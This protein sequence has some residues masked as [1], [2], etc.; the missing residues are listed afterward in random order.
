MATSA[1]NFVT[2]RLRQSAT[3]D[4]KFF[5]K[6]LMFFELKV[7]ASVGGFAGTSFLFPLIVP[8]Q[9]S[10][11]DEPFTVEVTPTQG[12]GLYV[13]ENGIVQRMIKISG[14]TGFKP[15]KLNANGTRALGIKAPEKR[16]FGRRLDPWVLE[17]LSGQRHIQYLQDAVFRTYGDLKRD[18]N[19]SE[20]VKLIFHI[21]KDEESWLVI[22]QKFSIE[23][24]SSRATLYNYSID[25]LVVDA[26]VAVDEDFTEDTW[27]DKVKDAVQDIKTAIDLAQGAINDLTAVVGQI[28]GYVKNIAVIIDGVSGVINAASNFVQG[29]TDLVLS[30]LAIVESMAEVTD[31]ALTAYDTLE[32]S[33]ELLQNPPIPPSI[34]VKLMQL[35][36][37]M[38]RIASHPEVT[39]PD[40]GNAIILNNL[41][42]DARSRITA[43]DRSS[44]RTITSLADA[45]TMGTAVTAGDI[46]IADGQNNVPKRVS[47]N[48]RSGKR[49]T[50]TE[51]DTLASLAASHLGDARRWQDLAV[52]NG[53]KPPF[54]NKQAS[55]DLTKADE[56]VLPG[57]LGIGDKIVIPS[58]SKGT[59][60]L[61]IL[62]VLG[63]KP[64]EPLEVQLLGRDIALELVADES[65]PGNP[66][67]DIPIDV[68]G[69]SVDV[70]TVAGLANLSQGLTLRLNTEKGTDTLYK[71]LGLERVVGL[72]IAPLDLETMRFRLSQA[73]QQDPRIASVRQVVFQGL[74]NGAELDPSIPLDA[75]V[76]DI[77]AEVRG[78]TEGV[79]VRLVL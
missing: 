44:P 55:L 32:Q 47:P 57:S 54:I 7:P 62:P 6:M 37:A 70:K 25:L 39:A 77:T 33:K 38:E 56:A 59:A 35:T 53:L 10:N 43:N 14:T 23:R 26:A 61:P 22:P 52:V 17:A 63:V 64:W 76:A 49:V 9:S 28:K 69:G 73:I 3:G 48:Y 71:R 19:L 16:S 79:N 8:P 30:P 74:D 40:S 46:Q 75:V 31:S 24:S 67:Y 11:L 58:T 15:R 51:G 34:R 4:N 60:Q 2:E 5:K 45:Q 21:P 78:F 50:I 29:V 68:E 65:S 36:E 66:V 1:L 27:L 42:S 41:R 72:N 12:G 18:P 13:E 20:N